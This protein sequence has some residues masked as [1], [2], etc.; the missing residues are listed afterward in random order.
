M[1]KYLTFLLFLIIPV[2]TW[3]QITTTDTKLAF[4]YYRNKEYAKA[5][6]IYKNLFESSGSRSYLTYYLSCLMELQE[7]DNAEK[8]VRQQIKKNPNELGYLVDLGYILKR[9]GK[10]KE[11]RES[12]DKAVELLTADDGQVQRLAMAFREKFENDYAERTYIKGREMLRNKSLYRNDLANVYLLERNYEDMIDEYLNMLDD[13]QLDISNVE[14]RLQSAMFMDFDN[15]MN[16]LIKTGILKRIQQHPESTAY[17]ELLIWLY[18]QDKDFNKAYIQ[19]KAL[20]KRASGQGDRIISL[21]RLAAV[22][23][24][25]AEA[26]GMY[27]Y[28]IGKGPATSNYFTAQRELLGVKL[29]HFTMESDVNKDSLRMLENEYKRALNEFGKTAKTISMIK[30]LAQIDAF[31]LNKTDDALNMLEIAVKMQGA[32]QQLI[33]D[34]KLEMADID[35][36]SGNIWEAALIYGQVE[37]SNENN[38]TGYEAKFRKARLAYYSGDFKWAQAQ[39]DVLK[40]STSKLI[41]NDACELSLLI[42]DNTEMDTIEDAM[43]MYARADLLS[44]QQQDSL[45]IVTLDSLIHLFPAHSLIDETY[46]KK[47]GI[48]FKMG[49]YK[50]AADSYQIVV[51]KYG[52]DILGDDALYKLACLYED[53][54]NDIPKAME[55]Y[56]KFLTDYP[57]SIYVVEVR[58]IY[59]KLRGDEI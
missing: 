24:N 13:N 25:Y 9:R 6:I 1:K 30:E 11:G 35:L 43:R 32:S 19:A 46:Y 21:A 27:L 55:L 50:E 44:Y 28:V 29:V 4:E 26:V 58:K 51:D 45:A 10:E 57:G 7:F 41:A 59:R 39:L 16:S 2:I 12:Y 36:L 20:D 48:L 37:K 5:I 31:Y 8:L 15:N 52:T 14:M 42:S 54:L 53:Q 17:Y 34:C 18:V 23:D 47:A 38:P 49:K 56:K 40:A 3:S 22:N 33:S